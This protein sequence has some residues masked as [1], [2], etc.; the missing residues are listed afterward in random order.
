[1]LLLIS[2][3]AVPLVFAN[4]TGDT[5]V[6]FISVVDNGNG[7]Q[8]W[9]YRVRITHPQS[10][11]TIAWCGGPNSI[12]GTSHDYRYHE[13]LEGLTTT[14]LYGIRFE[15]DTELQGSI[16]TY[17]FTL[18]GI[19]EIGD[20]DVEI[21]TESPGDGGRT[22]ILNTISGPVFTYDLALRRAGEGTETIY[23]VAVAKTDDMFINSVMFNWFGPFETKEETG[24]Y[25]TVLG[26]PVWIDVD[27]VRV[28]GFLTQHK[29]TEEHLGYWYIET[30]FQDGKYKGRADGILGLLI[31][32]R[33]MVNLPF[34]QFI[35]YYCKPLQNMDPTLPLIF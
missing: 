16:V 26:N 32:T 23:M 30:K 21:V 8:T 14:S 11:W 29:V 34:A 13:D 5:Y 27:A 1:M 35:Y 7:T 17:W 20:V 24:P 18:D 6:E 25:A 12:V 19:Y 31:P 28:G 4:F 33:L 15:M 9:T 3:V 22:R 2:I 10:H